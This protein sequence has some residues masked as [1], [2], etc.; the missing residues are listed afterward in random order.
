MNIMEYKEL[1]MN[2][3]FYSYDYYIT[4]NVNIE[5]K[6]IFKLECSHLFHKN[7]ILEWLKNKNTCP[8]CRQKRI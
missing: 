3:T 6:K 4:S 2:K 1:N 7:C 8:I 5:Q